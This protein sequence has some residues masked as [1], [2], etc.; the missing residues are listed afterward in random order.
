[1]RQKIVR[2]A[3]VIAVLGVWAHS[4]LPP[5]ISS[6]ESGWVT[7]VLIN[8]VW[9][10]LF[11]TDLSTGV[12]RKLAHVFEYA[13]VGLLLCAAM[14]GSTKRVL[15][16]CLI[17]AFLDETVQ[18]F[19]GRG[20]MIADVWIDLVGASFG[21]A[22]GWLFTAKKRAKQNEEDAASQGDTVQASGDRA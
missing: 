12:V 13:V 2:A 19:S 17:I 15:M 1:M 20:P 3:C 9:N 21:H 18:I 8:P 22:I 11:H 7:N 14:D 6:G 5:S 4:M 10:F 16:G